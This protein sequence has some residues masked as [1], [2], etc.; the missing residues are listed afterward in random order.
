M[1]LLS[2]ISSGI[3]SPVA[4]FLLSKKAYEIILVH[5]DNRPFTDNQ[6]IENFKKLSNHLKKII[7]SKIK[8]YLISHGESLGC[9]KKNCNDRFTCIFCKRMM[10]RYAEKIAQNEGCDAIIMGDSL[11]QV[12]SQTLQNIQTIEAAINMPVLRPLIGLDKEDVIKIA[13]KIGTYNLSILT[14][15][16][17]SAVPN[18]PAT[19]A[20]INQIEFEEEKIKVNDLVKNSVKNLIIYKIK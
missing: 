11:G 19:M 16:G 18:K 14:S 13:K 5:T 4:T 9:Y 15:E 2:L 3:D 6:E 12:A 1:K 20:K 8:V 7:K 17:C 10:L